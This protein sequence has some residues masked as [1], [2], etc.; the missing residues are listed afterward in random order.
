MNE[1]L[2]DYVKRKYNLLIG[3][4]TAERLKLRLGTAYPTDDM[5]SV[6]IKGRDLISGT[7]KIAELSS[8]ETRE[9]LAEPIASIVNGVRVTLERT[10]PELSADIA[11]RGIVMVGGGSLLCHLDVLLREATGLPV[12]IADDPLN[13]V[14]AGVGRVIDDPDVYRD[15]TSNDA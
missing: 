8:E 12:V 7:P 10:P 11:E 2:K 14:A 9:A 5:R 6:E 4:P 1:A 3:D 15:F 13:A